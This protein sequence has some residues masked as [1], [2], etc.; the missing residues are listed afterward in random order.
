M[1][2]R[3]SI[4]SLLFLSTSAFSQST[5]FEMIKGMSIF[6]EIYKEVNINFVDQ[7]KSG[8]LIKIGIDAMLKSLDP[9]TVYYP[10]TMIED[11]RI[12]QAEGFAAVGLV[13]DSIDGNI[14]VIEVTPGSSSAEK[15]VK[16]GFQLTSINS[17]STEDLKVSDVSKMLGGKEGTTLTLEFNT[18]D[19]QESFEIVRGNEES[20][21]VS[22]YGKTPQGHGYIKLDQ[23]SRTAYMEVLA[24]YE[25]LQQDDGI[26]GLVLDLRNNGGGL[27]V[28]AV[29]IVNMFV[30]KDI[31]VVEMKG[32][33][34]EEDKVFLTPIEPIAKDIPLIVLV[35]E[36]SASASEIVSGALQDLDRAVVIGVPSF[37]K[38]L[39]QITKNIPYGAQMK[40]TIAKYYTP[41]GRCVQKYDYVQKGVVSD[42]KVSEF[43][44]IGGRTVI[45]NRGVYPDV[46][47][48]KFH[49]NDLYVAIEKDRLIQ[50]FAIQYIN[51]NIGIDSIRF[52]LSESDIFNFLSFIKSESPSITNDNIE[53]Y[54]KFL[55]AM[56]N[57]NIEM[58]EVLKNQLDDL[59]NPNIDLLFSEIK[60]P[61]VYKLQEEI[62]K[63]KYGYKLAAK[64][65]LSNDYHISFASDYIKDTT[66]YSGLLKP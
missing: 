20:L 34:P 22:Y 8:E 15:G 65:R 62:I 2:K 66:K 49:L 5:S 36:R 6:N 29:K 58:K 32:R 54:K 18:G 37:G 55:A 63:M 46:E 57:G 10:E 61:L 44:T 39:V 25:E 43:K 60:K 3:L 45:G 42:S 11:Y 53:A 38:G 28:E 17:K 47:M 40:I 31:K 23:F 19:K 50:K 56:Y 52:N 35:N 13:L 12:K 26:E 41:S 16:V 48:D 7:P 27:L 14:T 24:A 9:Y 59:I 21:T 33:S 51:E 4:F 30:D 1:I 64:Y